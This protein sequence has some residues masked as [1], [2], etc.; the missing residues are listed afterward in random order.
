MNDVHDS[1]TKYGFGWS[2][3]EYDKSGDLM[4]IAHNNGAGLWTVNDSVMKALDWGPYHHADM[5]I[6]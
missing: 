4:D 3:F 5:L 6:A 1:I 2:T